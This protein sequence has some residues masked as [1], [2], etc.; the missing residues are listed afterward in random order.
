MQ[1]AIYTRVSHQS[2]ADKAT[3]LD[4]QLDRLRAY[5]KANGMEIVGEYSDPAYS[6]RNFDR[7]GYQEMLGD[8]KPKAIK[9]VVVYSLSRFGRNTVGIITQILELQKQGVAFHC[10]DLN[11]DTS[12]PMGNAMLTI[13]AA[14]AQLE[15]DQ[16]SARI[17]DV[18]TNRKGKMETYCGNPPLGYKNSRG[19]LVEVE[20]EMKIV[21]LVFEMRDLNHRR[22]AGKLNALGLRGKNG[23]R[24]AAATIT[25]ILNNKIYEQ[26]KTVSIS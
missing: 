23:G 12:T 17:R 22:I 2:Q 15:S 14:M 5:C 25:K 21:K 10:L 16:T 7:P 1:A 6:G 8:L 18:Q 4:N 19:K 11:I 26:G 3:S 24:F 9:A 20:D 13:F